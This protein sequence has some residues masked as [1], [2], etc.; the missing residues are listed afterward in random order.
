VQTAG[1][2]NGLIVLAIANP[3]KPVEVCLYEAKRSGRDRII[4]AIAKVPSD[5]PS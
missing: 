5:K 3:V 4:V 2:T 1:A